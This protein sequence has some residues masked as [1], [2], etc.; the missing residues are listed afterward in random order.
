MRIRSLA[1][2]V[3]FAALSLS[4]C[5]SGNGSAAGTPEPSSPPAGPAAAS[6]TPDDPRRGGTL[7]YALSDD[8][9]QIDPAF[10]ADEEG[11]FVV[12]ALFDSLVALDEDQQVVPAAARDWEVSENA[13]VFT[14]RL[15]PDAT[16]HDGTPVT[17]QDFV[18]AF[19][20]MADG[21]RDPSSFVAYHLA[22]VQGF[23]QTQQSGVPLAG[24]EAAD[25]FT[26]RITLVEPFAEFLLV[27]SD[28]SLAPIPEVADRNPE[29]FAERPVGNGPFE[30]AEPWQHGQYIR[31]TRYPDHHRPA[32]LDEVVF[33]IYL[34]DAG[35]D[36][37]YQAFTDGQLQVAGVPPARLEEAREA[38][39]RS[40]D[41]YA[42]PGVLDGTSSTLYYFG[43][44]TNE[45]PFDDPDVRRAVS[46]SI[47]REEI[48]TE[49]MR[50]ARAP[51]DGI[52]PP[53]IPGHGDD[54]CR[55]CRFDPEQAKE[56]V[57]DVELPDSIELLYNVGQSHRA[58]ADHVAANIQETLGVEVEL[59]SEELQPF[60]Q[61][62]RAGNMDLFR[63]GWQADYPSAGSYLY[64]LFSSATLG[65]D[66]LTRFSS[67]DV[68]QKLQQARATRDEAERQRLYQ[69][70]ERSVLNQ[71]VIAP[72]FFYRF[73]LVTADEVRDFRI[74]PM[75]RVDLTTVWLGSAE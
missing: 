33:Q 25:Q 61:T 58:I 23:E 1:T 17:A 70:V 8:P 10:V 28:P 59:S 67:S 12:D 27:L 26:L 35:A 75:G 40:S 16:F 46:L 15:R 13:T 6:A 34:Q 53:S 41:G 39:G 56:L 30:M 37:Q 3:A 22:P 21:T 48:A 24:V 55:F 65:Q 51:A 36:Q 73:N 20:R 43:F 11:E 9:E 71:A 64:P 60:V 45:A 49:V 66:N 63:L 29:G 14:F 18:R 54:A 2:L 5:T 4:A 72:V 68:D 69:E 57:E 74:T 31:V 52:V 44:N 50:G 42:A 38:H 47:D 32:W 19:N 62:L 7:R